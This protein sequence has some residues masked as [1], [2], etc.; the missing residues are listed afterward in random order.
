MKHL[1]VRADRNVHVSDTSTIWPSILTR[2]VGTN[3]EGLQVV[4]LAG[5]EAARLSANA[6]IEPAAASATTKT[7]SR[8]RRVTDNS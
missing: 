4:F 6:A 5:F 3:Q 1:A 7:I 8:T 2:T